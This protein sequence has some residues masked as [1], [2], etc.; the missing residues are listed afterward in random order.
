MNLGRGS[1]TKSLVGPLIVIKA[2]SVTNDAAGVLQGFK[3]VAVYALTLQ[4][5]DD[6]LH[7]AVL[8][9]RVRRDEFLL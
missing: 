3:A 5:T 9:P 1:H 4:G 2:N 6:A 7:R 8:F